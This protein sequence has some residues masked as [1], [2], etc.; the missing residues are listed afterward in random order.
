MS[1]QDKAFRALR[2]LYERR[3]GEPIDSLRDIRHGCRPEDM[4]PGLYTPLPLSSS[5]AHM[6]S[7]PE[8]FP[9]ALRLLEKRLLDAANSYFVPEVLLPERDYRWS[10]NGQTVWIRAPGRLPST[11]RRSLEPAEKGVFL[12]MDGAD[13]VGL[14]FVCGKVARRWGPDTHEQD[15]APPNPSK[16]QSPNIKEPAMEEKVH[17]LV[18]KSVSLPEGGWGEI[19]AVEVLPTGPWITARRGEDFFVFPAG[20]D[21]RI[22]T[23]GKGIRRRRGDGQTPG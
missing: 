15:L 20:K 11:L 8:G 4:L 21:V 10:A 13:L 7:M 3:S 17:P 22:T 1:A 18:G 9:G 16:E 14:C 6:Y 19:L 2:D 23:R 12:E 5:D